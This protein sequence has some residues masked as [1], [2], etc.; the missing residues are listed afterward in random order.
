M[1]E[2]S[3]ECSVRVLVWLC[4]INRLLTLIVFALVFMK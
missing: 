1:H 2:T 4:G 3:I